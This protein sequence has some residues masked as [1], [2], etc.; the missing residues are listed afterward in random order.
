VRLGEQ[1][2]L[3]SQHMTR[4]LTPKRGGE[5][6]AMSATNRKT[7]QGRVHGQL[8][9]SH[10]DVWFSWLL[11]ALRSNGK[12]A[13]P[14]GPDR[15]T[16]S[17]FA[18]ETAPWVRPNGGIF[19]EEHIGRMTPIGVHKAHQYLRPQHRKEL[20]RRCPPFRILLAAANSSRLRSEA[21]AV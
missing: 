6:A 10:V 2:K 14:A 16:A 17:R 11:Q 19:Y 4:C 8:H 20:A 1:V 3:S 15:A 18:I 9:I 13:I 7:L 5:V 21:S 12:L